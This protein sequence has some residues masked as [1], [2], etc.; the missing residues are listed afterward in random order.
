MKKCNL[1]ESFVRAVSSYWCLPHYFDFN[2]L[3]RRLAGAV[4]IATMVHREQGS[5]GQGVAL[6]WLAPLETGP[7]NTATLSL[8]APPIT[9]CNGNNPMCACVNIY[10]L[11]RTLQYINTLTII[12]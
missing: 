3:S 6:C 4:A 12:L 7:E 1:Y 10:I 8:N 5:L 9:H 11:I 2:D